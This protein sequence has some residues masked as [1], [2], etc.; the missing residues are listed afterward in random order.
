MRF[1]TKALVLLAALAPAACA[2]AQ[3]EP[4][5]VHGSVPTPPAF[6]LVESRGVP[7]PANDIPESERRAWIEANQPRDQYRPSQEEPVAE[8]CSYDDGCHGHGWGIGLP[9]SIGFGYS[10]GCGGGFGVGVNVC[11]IG[12]GVGLGGW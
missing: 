12:V 3:N 5:A 1:A 10:S 7:P 6:R 8:S 4:I 2:S 11:G 9:I